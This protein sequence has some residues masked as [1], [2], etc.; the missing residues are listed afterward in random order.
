MF[1]P[2]YKY[3][4]FRTTF[5]RQVEYS[6]SGFVPTNK[7]RNKQKNVSKVQCGSAFEP[8][9]SGLPYYCTSIC[10]FLLFLAR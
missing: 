4:H 9:A 1:V 10:A 3:I 2:T 5:M 8:G 6:F 7:Q